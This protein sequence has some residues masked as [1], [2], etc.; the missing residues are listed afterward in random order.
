MQPPVTIVIP[1]FNG[2]ELLRKNLP[3]VLSAMQAYPGPS[4]LIVVDDGSADH[5][6]EVLKQEFPQAHVVIHPHN[7]G[8][9]EAIHSG[10]HAANT[11]LLF[12]LNSDVAVAPDIFAPLVAYF[13]DPHAFSVNPLIYDEQ[14]EVK[15]HAWNLRKFKAGTLKLIS[16]QLD[17]ALQRRL[18]G[19]KL[20]TAYAHG[21]SFMVRKSMFLAL[22]GFHPIFKP[23]YS[24]DYDLGLRAWRRGWASY[25]EP[26]VHIVHQS[27]G[28]IRSNVKFKY[29]KSIRRRNRYIL[30]WAHLGLSDLLFKAL[31][32]SILQLLGELLT[33][34]YTNLRGFSFAVMKLNEVIAFR[35]E[36]RKTSAFTLQDVLKN[37]Y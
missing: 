15:R 31:P 26:G 5:S 33:L 24:E 18:A 6:L 28:A 21:G 37:I 4:N 29:V 34:D 32:A 19:D 11:E 17:N 2:A 10:V 27:K 1:N 8:F 35:R 12:L 36:L 3:S 25:F 22:G 7:K 23:F 9:A 20:A 14:G 16:W 13:D 30:E